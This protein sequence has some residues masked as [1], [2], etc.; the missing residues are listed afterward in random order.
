M[1]GGAPRQQAGAGRPGGSAE[2]WGNKITIAD[3]AKT[4]EGDRLS[5]GLPDDD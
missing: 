4:L 3:A 5:A 1:C 2:A